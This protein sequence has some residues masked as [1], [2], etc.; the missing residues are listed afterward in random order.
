METQSDHTILCV[1]D[2]PS[3]LNALKRLFRKERYQILAATDAEKAF[4][5]MARHTVHLVLCDNRMPGISGIDFLGKIKEMYPDTIRIILT[6]YTEVNSITDAINRGSIY[7]F[8]L[9][10]WNDQSLKLEIRQALEQFNLTQIN[11]Q[12][13]QKVLQQNVVLRQMN[14]DLEAAVHKR[15]RELE[16]QNQ[17]L[18]L[19]RAI[20]EDIPIGIIGVSLEGTIVLINRKASNLRFQSQAMEI[21][22]SVTEYFPEIV[23]QKINAVFQDAVHRGLGFFKLLDGDFHLD[24]VPLGGKFIGKGVIITLRE[25]HGAEYAQTVDRG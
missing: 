14:E 6:G 4:K 13:N 22:R 3:I 24:I 12:L 1:D 25:N 20:L 15:T 18:E 23:I 9:K 2:E 21:G 19:S 7:K 16:I 5:L 11:K 8:L 17:A 10:P